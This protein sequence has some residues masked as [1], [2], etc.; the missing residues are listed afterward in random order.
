LETLKGL[1][2]MVR[3]E[4]VFARFKDGRATFSDLGGE[5]RTK[6]HYVIDEIPLPYPLYVSPQLGVKLFVAYQLKG[7]RRSE[8]YVESHPNRLALQ[9]TFER[10]KSLAH[11][12]GFRVVVIIAPNRA[13]CPRLHGAQFDRVGAAC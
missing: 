13:K 11:R 6:G 3:Q 2:A 12:A 5:D 7:A 8:R 4:S 9:K 1:P 10:I